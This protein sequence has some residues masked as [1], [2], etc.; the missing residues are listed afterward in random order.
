M[1]EARNRPRLA[2]ALVALAALFL[3]ARTVGYEYV[4]DDNLVGVRSY[5]GLKGALKAFT[6]PFFLPYYY[7]PVA[8]LSFALSG[9]PAIQHAINTLLHA[10]NASLVFYC[11]RALMPR[12]VSGSNAGAWVPALAALAFAVHP[13]TVEAVAWVSG[14]FDTLMCT[15]VLGTCLAALGGKLTHRRLALVF[16]LFA[17]AMGS[18]E[19]AIGLLAALPFL[20]LLKW[21]LAGMGATQIKTQVGTPVRLLAAMT[22]VVLLYLAA[23]WSVIR[24][25]FPSG[26]EIVF[27]GAS[28]LDRL[29]I[30]AQ[31]ITALAQLVVMPLKYSAPLHPFE[32]GNGSGFLPQTLVV[33]ACLPTLLALAFWKKTRFHFPLALLSALAMSWPVLHIFGIPNRDN[34]ISD[35]YVLMPM[36]LLLAALAAVAACKAAAARDSGKLRVVMYSQVACLLWVGMLAAY[37]SVTIPLWR[38]EITLWAFAHKQVPGSRAAYLNYIATLMMQKRWSEANIEMEHYMNMFPAARRNLGNIADWVLIRT[39]IG[40]H[41][42]A[43]ELFFAAELAI[44]QAGAHGISERELGIFYGNGG[45]L[46]FYAGN[47][48]LAVEYLEKSLYISRNNPGVA[49]LLTKARAARSNQEKPD[50]A[51]P[52]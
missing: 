3:Y 28:L 8:L 49:S 27:G 29:N 15:F 34:I 9:Q 14:R 22:L 36:A 23:R 45:T 17:C 4:W 46:E 51:R 5:T 20:L 26:V 41:D 24:L 43:R 52:Q 25:L 35:R 16:V 31:T 2:A 13:V 38:N 18:K 12:E 47:M 19:S 21:R 42:G 39:N 32:Y 6:E 33:I 7:R 44:K 10:L 1:T 48:E 30:A 50:S 40:D 37:S 11:A